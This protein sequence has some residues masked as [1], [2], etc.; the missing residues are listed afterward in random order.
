MNCKS[1]KTGDLILKSF[2]LQEYYLAL[3]DSVLAHHSVYAG[4]HVFSC[5]IISSHLP[6][7]VVATFYLLPDCEDVISSIDT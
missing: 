1:V 4:H 3:N 5:L 6:V 7:R 2:G